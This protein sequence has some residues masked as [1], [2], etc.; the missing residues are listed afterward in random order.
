EYI[1]ALGPNLRL[2]HDPETPQPRRSAE[3]E[4]HDRRNDPR[5]HVGWEYDRDLSVRRRLGATGVLGEPCPIGRKG[6]ER[7]G[8][9]ATS[10]VAEP[11]FPGGPSFGPSERLH[12]NLRLDRGVRVGIGEAC[13]VRD[14]GL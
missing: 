1:Q 6:R 13:R 8:V 10:E 11:I 12:R 7:T 2:R 5:E 3:L 4:A 9:E 14:R